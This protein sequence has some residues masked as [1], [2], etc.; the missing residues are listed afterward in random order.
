[1]PILRCLRFIKGKKAKSV[2][3]VNIT[4]NDKC[5]SR[6]GK[7]NR[8]RLTMFKQLC[9]GSKWAKKKWRRTFLHEFFHLFGL[10]HVQSRSDRNKYI[11][12]HEENVKPNKRGQFKICPAHRCK[13][14]GTYECDSIMH[15]GKVIH[16]SLITV[17]QYG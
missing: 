13:T 6:G 15:Y 11:Q 17:R 2:V 5:G 9:D 14:C 7:A 12:F 16:C 8:L 4:L 3:T 1:M 10:I